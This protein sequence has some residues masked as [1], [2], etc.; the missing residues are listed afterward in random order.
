MVP[1]HDPVRAADPRDRA[2]TVAWE[3]ALALA[4]AR[5]T[6]TCQVRPPSQEVLVAQRSRIVQVGAQGAICD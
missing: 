3:E 1:C 6:G 5:R 2:D 4:D